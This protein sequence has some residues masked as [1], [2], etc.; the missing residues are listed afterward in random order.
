MARSKKFYK[1]LERLNN[2]EGSLF[3]EKRNLI[4]RGVFHYKSNQLYLED[5]RIPLK[6]IR[7]IDSAFNGRGLVFVSLAYYNFKQ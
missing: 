6:H 7:N 4:K 1:N 5:S 3:D 2:L